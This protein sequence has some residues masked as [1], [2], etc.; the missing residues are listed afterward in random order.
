MGLSDTE[1]HFSKSKSRFCAGT[2]RLERQR[3]IQTKRTYGASQCREHCPSGRLLCSAGS[4]K[5]A[6]KQQSSREICSVTQ[7]HSNFHL[8]GERL[9]PST[10]IVSLSGHAHAAAVASL[11]HHHHRPPPPI[12]CP[13]H[14]A[15]HCS[16]LH[17]LLPQP[18]LRPRLP[19]AHCAVPHQECPQPHLCPA[20]LQCWTPAPQH[21]AHPQKV[22]GCAVQSVRL[23]QHQHA[24]LQCSRYLPCAACLS[25]WHHLPLPCSVS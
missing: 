20:A 23:H 6:S 17:R 25:Q 5:H 12:P 14:L 10:G 15:A 7:A 8:P 1:Q 18:L 16:L 22:G 9:Y 2:G 19:A 11:A 3:D 24:L 4:R 21:L 13:R